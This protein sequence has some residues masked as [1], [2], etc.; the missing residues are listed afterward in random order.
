MNNEKSIKMRNKPIGLLIASMSWPAMLSM[1]VQAIYNVVDTY[2]V[3]KIDPSSNDLMTAVGYAFPLQILIL[4]LSLGI[5]IGTNVIIAKK[6]GERNPSEAS[7]V[8]RTGILMAMISGVFFFLLSFIIVKPFMNFMSDNPVIIEAGVSYLKIVMMFSFFSILEMVYSR[9]LQGMG[10]MIP[11]MISQLLGALINIFLDPILISGKY[12]FPALGVAG[13]AIATVFA[14][15]ISLVFIIIFVYTRKFEISLGIKR[16]KLQIIYV[17]QIIKIG[18]PS[19][20]MNAIGALVNVFL[21]KILKSHDPTEVANGVLVAFSKLQ[22]FVFMPVFGLNQGGM[23][24]LSYNYGANDKKRFMKG[25]KILTYSALI[26]MSAGFLIFQIIP[27]QLL[28]IFS[29]TDELLE[30]GIPA[31]RIISLAFIPAAI[32]I[33]TTMTYQALGKGFTA[34][35]MSLGR[36]AVLLVPLAFILGKIG[37][38]NFIWAA[39]PIAEIIITVIFYLILRKTIQEAFRSRENNEQTKVL[40]F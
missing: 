21:N 26:I 30:V 24:I 27:G 6:L 3:A 38:L 5:G 20:V 35:F 14:Q 15:F 40:E 33:I 23:P 34:L 36:Q 16:F 22:S 37:G 11:P 18:L 31:L 10:R 25:Y 17:G 2:Y 19:M 39:F 32:A 28:K 4:A 13:A 8:A 9:I 1:L 29:A 12:G 7:N